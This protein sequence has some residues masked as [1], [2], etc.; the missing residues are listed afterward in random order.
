MPWNNQTGGPWKGGNGGG[1]WGQGSRNTGGGPPN[2]PDLEQ[3]LRR[4]QDRLKKV[5]PTRGGGRPANPLAWAAVAFVVLAFVGY[6]FFTFRV[7]PDEL[8][9][10]LRFGG[11]N[12]QAQP[13]LSFRLPYPIETVYTPKVTR[14]TP[15]TIGQVQDERNPSAN[16]RGIPQESLMLTGD[17]NIVDIDFSVFW[18]INDA[19]KYLF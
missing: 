5:L 1:P 18:V 8:G 15:I 6:N 14:V 17:E 4:G 12:R 13:G 16:G 11:I 3:L 10:V 7:D 19:T 2:P 9:I